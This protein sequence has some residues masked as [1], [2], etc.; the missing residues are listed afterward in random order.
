VV[1]VQGDMKIGRFGLFE[2]YAALV[3]ALGRR[4]G[5]DFDELGRTS[6]GAPDTGHA[7]EARTLRDLRR[8]ALRRRAQDAARCAT[9][10]S[11]AV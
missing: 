4:Q 1:R 7:D 5:E 9:R 3:A 8:L 6:G 11:V 10:L 2:P